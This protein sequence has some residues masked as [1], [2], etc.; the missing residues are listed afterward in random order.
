MTKLGRAFAY[1][2][3]EFMVL[4]GL[5][6]SHGKSLLAVRESAQRVLN[7][8]FESLYLH[9]KNE[10]LPDFFG[11]E[12]CYERQLI[13]LLEWKYEERTRLTLYSSYWKAYARYLLIL[14]LM[15]LDKTIRSPR[16]LTEWA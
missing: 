5:E 6:E 15:D 16:K 7:P 2:L 13:R 14:L 8:L 4:L 9:L 1:P 3:G 10:F 12:R 11:V